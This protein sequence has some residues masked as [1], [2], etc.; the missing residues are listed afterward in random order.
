MNKMPALQRLCKVV[1]AAVFL[2]GAGVLPSAVSAESLADTLASAYEHSGLIERNRATLRAADEDVAIAVSALR[3]TLS[4]ALRSSYNGGPGAIEGL[5][6]TLTLSTDI[7]LFDFARNALA[8]EAQK[9]TVLATRELLVS[10]EQQA[11]LDAVNA[12]FDV[13]E[14]YETISL[15]RNNV[16]LITQE[17]RAA[18]DRFEV[19][20]VT[21]TDVALAQSRLASARSALAAAEGDLAISVAAF[22][23]A[24]GR[25]PGNLTQPARTPQLPAT[26]AEAK[27]IALRHHPEIKRVQH[28]ITANELNLERTRR[29]L[30]PTLSANGTSTFNLDGDNDRADSVSV[31]LGGPIYQGGNLNALI[32]KSQTQL[33]SSRAD[34]HVTR[35]TIEETVEVAYA[36]LAVARASRVASNEQIRAAT[37]AFRGVREEATLGARTTLDV[38]N[39]EQE[40]LDARA[41]L[42]TAVTAE[43][44]AAYGVLASLGRLTARDLKLNVQLYDPAGY[45]NLVKNAPATTISEQGRALQRVLESLGKN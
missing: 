25:A 21:R 41:S 32:R 16:R 1:S 12:Y 38:L 24:V 42:V 22:R 26:V 9:E 20:E 39:A 11:L 14:D 43:Y 8:V 2:G 34:L 28:I 18:E 36:R 5:S 40:L 6:N 45:Y 3:P 31:T 35:H 4:Y 19:G 7:T 10:V 29:G 13:R 44:Q 17:L 33:D 37:V 23:E 30:Y 15:R 27:S